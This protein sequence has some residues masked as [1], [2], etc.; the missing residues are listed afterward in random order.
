MKQKNK[1]SAIIA[2]YHGEK[3]IEPTLKNLKGVVDEIIVVHDGPCEDRTIK[4]A[5]KYT[6]KIYIRPRGGRTCFPFGFGLKKARYNWVLK[7]DDDETLSEELRNNIRDLIKTKEFD[8]FS[9]IHPLWDG[10]KPITKTWP[11]KTVLVRKS[12]IAYLGFPGFDM[13]INHTGKTKKTNYV[14]FHKPLQNQ[15][16]GWEGF[17]K[18][19]L[20]RYAPS[21]AKN[22]FRP[23][24][25]FPTFQYKEKDFPFKLKIR[26][27]LPIFTNTIY[28]FLAFFK[29]FFYDGAWREG[30]K[31]FMV[32]FKTFIYDIYLGYLI[33]KEKSRIRKREKIKK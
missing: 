12:K 30:R 32:V 6:K 25:D 4:I 29:H 11:R 16:V 23:F 31:G 17:K 26:K 21:Q 20:Q 28:A 15:D 3:T 18:K 2:V 14:M 7:M 5:K 8:A 19:V 13:N 24:T 1:I 9:F 22:L 27:T 33:Q 10:K